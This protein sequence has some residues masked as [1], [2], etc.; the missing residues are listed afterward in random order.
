MASDPTDMAN[1]ALDEIGIPFQLGDIEQGGREANVCNRAYNECL[2]QLLR[3]APWAFARK[4][5]TMQLLADA[6]GATPNVSNVVVG[7][8]AN[9]WCYEYAYPI[10]CARIRYVPGNQLSTPGTPAGN[11]TPPN[12]NLPILPN[13]GTAPWG[14]RVAPT[15]FLVT[16]DPNFTVGP[17]TSAQFQQGQSPVGS[18]VILSNVQNATLVYTFNC[19][20]PSLWDHLFRGA[21]VSYLGQAIALPL[22]AGR[23]KPDVGLKIRMQQI[24]ITKQKITEARVADGN[25]MTVSSDIPVDWIRFRRTGGGLNNYSLPG[26]NADYGCWGGG[27]NGSL[28]FGDGTS[29]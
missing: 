25:E 27:W 21:L 20:Y 6:S 29:Y 9:K 11:I 2:R 18:T 19:L 8:Y 16:N 3:A 22:W 4:Q 13:T 10:D 1:L 17:N 23:N 7:G 12:P 15:P 24:A 26:N 14:T 5:T 28:V